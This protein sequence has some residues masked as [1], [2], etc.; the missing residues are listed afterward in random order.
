MPPVATN[1]AQKL[2]DRYSKRHRS[3]SRNKPR[4]LAQ[5]VHAANAEKEYLP[6]K[7]EKQEKKGNFLTRRFQTAILACL[8]QAQRSLSRLVQRWRKWRV[9]T[10][11]ELHATHATPER[12][13]PEK[14]SYSGRL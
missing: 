13:R 10:G 14:E 11:A 12:K 1:L 9:A 8:V 7:I 4:Q 2:P 3:E 6:A 5:L